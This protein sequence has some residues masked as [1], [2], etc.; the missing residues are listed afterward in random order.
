MNILDDGGVHFGGDALR[1]AGGIEE[2]ARAQEID[3]EGQGRRVGVEVG[4]AG[5]VE[6]LLGG[7]LELAVGE[8]DLLL[9][10]CRLVDFVK[11]LDADEAAADGAVLAVVGP[12]LGVNGPAAAVVLAAQ[13]FV[14]AEAADEHDAAAA[15]A[16]V[17]DARLD[18]PPVG[19]A[20][21]VAVAEVA[22][23]LLV[24]AL[25]RAL[26]LDGHE[27]RLGG[28]GVQVGV[29]VG[30]HVGKVLVAGQGDG[31]GGV[32]EGE[33]VV[34]LGDGDSDVEEADAV[35]EL[36]ADADGLAADGGQ[37]RVT[38]RRVVGAGDGEEGQRVF[39]AQLVHPGIEV[40]R[41]HD[42]EERAIGHVDGRQLQRR[43]VELL[44]DGRAVGGARGVNLVTVA[45]DFELETNDI[46][47]PNVWC[48]NL[49]AADGE[50]LDMNVDVFG[51]VGIS[52]CVGLFGGEVGRIHK[53]ANGTK[54][55]AQEVSSALPLALE[56]F[57]TLE[58][59]GQ[60][61]EVADGEVRHGGGLEQ[62]GGG[63]GE[64]K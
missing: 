45:L 6:E 43:I 39:V 5:E 24:V 20:A 44:H 38:R 50:W 22:A 1:P 58:G 25:A 59:D 29:D 13:G 49:G 51:L 35:V 48:A 28:V 52:L 53:G 16:E 8:V 54:G 37:R 60:G 62:G 64:K 2:V 26:A 34:V 33:V 61:R 41:R 63:G 46:V 27:D 57:D 14:E 23:E 10:V 56:A 9:D 32:D 18:E 17:R 40:C 55:V 21:D 47:V 11:V 4:H 30:E 12:V 19:V 3:K 36:L 42:G 31:E 7:A 15:V